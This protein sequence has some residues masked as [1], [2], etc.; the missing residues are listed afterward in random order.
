MPKRKRERKQ[1]RKKNTQ[2]EKKSLLF[3][4]QKLGQRVVSINPKQSKNKGITRRG[5][6]SERQTLRG[7]ATRKEGVLS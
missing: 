3:T 7:T 2:K 6:G 4:Y 1:D 5:S